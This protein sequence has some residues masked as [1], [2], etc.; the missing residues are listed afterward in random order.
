MHRAG[1]WA[2]R[3]TVVLVASLVACGSDEQDFGENGFDSGGADRGGAGG[4]D[5]GRADASMGGGAGATG[6][7][8]SA[9]VDTRAERDAI[10]NGDSSIDQ[11]ATDSAVETSSTDASD[12]RVADGDAP[13][14][15]S[16]DAQSDA[17]SDASDGTISCD[18]NDA[19]TYDFYSPLYGCGHKFDA[20]PNDGDAWITYDVGF[21]VDVATGLGW[22]FPGP[23]SAAAAAA[24]CDAL[25]V[26]GLSDW[27]MVN[28]DDVRTIAAGCAT[29]VAGGPCPL[30]DPSCLA[31]S[32]AQQ[33]PDCNSC[34]GGSIGTG[35]HAGAYCKVDVAVCNNFHTSSLCTDCGDAGPMDWIYGPTNGN[36]VALDSTAAIPSACVS[37]VPNGVPPANGG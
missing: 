35:P 30:H 28:I 20:N 26:A 33:I 14:D 25:S 4:S 19:A 1:A 29:T 24:A 18:D 37:T 15:T 2:S 5:A 11:S 16:A 34:L 27:R 10:A 12:V 22:A 6:G 3:V 13:V 8:D 31:M 9:V 32:C 21:H 7:T 36:F 23:R 17:S